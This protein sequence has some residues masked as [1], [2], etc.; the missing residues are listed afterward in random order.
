VR[1]QLDIGAAPIR[2][3]VD[4]TDETLG[5]HLIWT[6]SLPENIR[7]LT[8]VDEARYGRAIVVN[9]KHS[10]VWIQRSTI[11][12]ELCHALFDRVPGRPIGVVS[13]SAA[14]AAQE[15]LEQRANAFACYF[16]VPRDS[17]KSFLGAQGFRPRDSMDNLLLH[18]MSNHFGVGIDLLT[19]HLKHL[20]QIDDKNRRDLID[21]HYPF[22]PSLDTESPDN[23]GFTQW[24]KSGV[25]VERLCLVSPI[26]EAL[27]RNE[28]T[29]DAAKEFL[30][31][32]PFDPWPE[33]PIALRP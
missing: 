33:Q 23:R 18:R 3:L 17:A 4:V 20:D 15:A 19:G 30:G 12:H 9:L 31:L 29:L 32:S 11:A 27:Q 10:G 1:T 7:G 8:L 25:D 28:I 13:R 21:R 2:S 22:D 24:L 14:G 5:I 6:R 26:L 16:L